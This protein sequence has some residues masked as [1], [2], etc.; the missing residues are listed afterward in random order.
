[1]APNSLSEMTLMGHLYLYKCGFILDSIIRAD[2]LEPG[3]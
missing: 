3:N 1:M 2:I